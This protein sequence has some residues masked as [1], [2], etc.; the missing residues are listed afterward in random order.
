MKIK[1]HT[2]IYYSGLDNLTR[3]IKQ[4]MGATTKRSSGKVVCF[5]SSD[6]TPI[7][8]VGSETKDDINDTPQSGTKE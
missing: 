6:A 5:V 4:S 8:G 7:G 3:K 1:P 2:L